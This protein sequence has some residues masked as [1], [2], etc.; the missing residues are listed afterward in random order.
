M[1][2]QTIAP[3]TMQ[4]VCSVKCCNNDP[5]YAKYIRRTAVAEQTIVEMTE[6]TELH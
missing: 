4:V 6:W 5:V 3:S 2:A 1:I